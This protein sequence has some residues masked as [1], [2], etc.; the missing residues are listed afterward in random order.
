MEFQTTN[1]IVGRRRWLALAAVMV[2][3]F[4]SAL[5]QT[6]VTTALPTIIGELN[7]LSLYAWVFTAYMM[8]SAITVPLYGK[9]SDIYGRKP[10][11]L[12]GLGLFMIGSALAG[13]AHGMG[14]LIAA[15]A[16]QG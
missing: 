11:Y 4:F 10:F 9:L 1:Q 16:I 5:D 3:M 2:T 14:W 15:R 6:V 8:T 13:L 7:G 12:F